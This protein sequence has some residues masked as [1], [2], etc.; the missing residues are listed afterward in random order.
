MTKAFTFGN[1][2]HGI[3]PLA[4]TPGE[5]SGVKAVTWKELVA[6][7]EMADFEFLEAGARLDFAQ[8][9]HV[10]VMEFGGWTNWQTFLFH[11]TLQAI[12]VTLND[13][14][15]LTGPLCYRQVTPETEVSPPATGR[16][17]E[18]QYILPGLGIAGAAATFAYADPFYG[19]LVSI[20]A[21]LFVAMS[22]KEHYDQKRPA[23]VAQR[24]TFRVLGPARKSWN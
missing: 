10:E 7:G 12:D 3:V 8:G 15:V 19:S 23:R 6:P 16:T 5:I 20:I 24:G 9:G 11:S 1:S 2:K 13:G 22:L 21:V 17:F 14:A 18:D 4:P